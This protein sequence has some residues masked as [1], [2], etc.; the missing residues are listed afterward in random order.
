[1]PLDS[2]FSERLQR[3][4]DA[5]PGEILIDAGFL[6][7]AE[8]SNLHSQL[9]SSN[10]DAAKKLGRPG[11][12]D[13]ER[14]FGAIANIPEQTR[15]WARRNGPQFGLSIED[16]WY[17]TPLGHQQRNPHRYL[18][19]KEVTAKDLMAA[20]FGEL[21]SNFDKERDS[22]RESTIKPQIPSSADKY[23]APLSDEVILSDPPVEAPSPHGANPQLSDPQP[24]LGR[25]SEAGGYAE[26]IPQ[27]TRKPN[28]SMPTAQYINNL[29]V[30]DDP[31][32]L[33]KHGEGQRLNS[34]GEH[35]VYLDGK[36]N[37]TGGH[38]HLITEAGY[39]VGD[40]I[41][42]E[43][44]ND[45]FEADY[46]E[47]E[48]QMIKDLTNAGVDLGNVSDNLYIHLVDFTFNQGSFAKWPN[49]REQIAAGDWEG[50]AENVW[51][52]WF[53]SYENETGHDFEM[54]DGTYDR[55]LRLTLAFLEE[56]ARS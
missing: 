11:K 50:A 56:A 16:D 26:F 4:I 19:G 40:V 7:R 10:R 31:V 13:M 23:D 1:M 30:F 51:S 14:G 44:V 33:I 22:I 46:R 52:D 47:H 28:Y 43:T 55:K 24:S 42:I 25:V 54:G 3:F 34:K 15:D 53:T 6:D 20:A 9:L 45:W 21:H 32:D 49:L 8:Y 41:P 36:G 5:A 35:V 27:H 29:V 2:H 37:K 17:I 18:T 48:E 12:S 39:E 38:G